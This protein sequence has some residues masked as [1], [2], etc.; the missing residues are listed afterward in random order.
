MPTLN[1]KV[2]MKIPPGTQAGRIFR[3]KE[4]GIPDVHGRSIGDE[5]VRVNVEIPAHLTSEQRRLIEEFAR[6]SGED[7]NKESFT[8]KIKKAFK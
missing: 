5:L 7:T 2:E 8:A 1:G 4:K 3:L 6:V